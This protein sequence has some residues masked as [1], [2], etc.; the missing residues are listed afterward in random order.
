MSC[1]GGRQ[2]SSVVVPV[3]AGAVLCRSAWLARTH[4][5]GD[6]EQR[7]FR[8]FNDA[9]DALCVP[10]W[11][12]MQ[13]G[14]LGGVLI[15]AAELA[16]RRRTGAATTT[17]VVGTAVWAGVKLVKPLVGRG[18]PQH[19]LDGVSLRGQPQTGLG[20]PSGHAAVALTLALLAPR[21]ATTSSLAA[22]TAFAGV[23]GS[24]RMYVG[25]HLPL[26]VVGGLAIGLLA[27]QATRSVL[28]VCR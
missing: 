9:P 8:R 3:I 19:Y 17:A 23:V 1:R 24:T 25:A 28:A 21:A 5:V 10:A 6:A 16:R 26:D 14:S 7:I 20:Y 13:S 22:G 4:A 15:T 2:I 11:V 12:I 18:R 27:G